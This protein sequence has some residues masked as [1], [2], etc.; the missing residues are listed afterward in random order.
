VGLTC[1]LTADR[2]VPG[3]RL[4]GVAAVR[5]VLPL[6]DAADY[7]V[8]GVAAAAVPSHRPPGRALV[9]DAASECQLARWNGAPSAVAQGTPRHDGDRPLHIAELPPDPVL[10]AEGG[11]LDA[12][13]DGS[14]HGSQWVTVG[15]G[16]DE[17]HLLR[18]DLGRNGG[19][20]VIGP[21]GSGRTRTLDALVTEL[22]AGGVPVLRVDH[23]RPSGPDELAFERWIDPRDTE[24]LAAWLD[25]LGRRGGVVVADDVGPAQDWPVLGQLASGERSRAPALIVAGSPAELAAHYQGPVAALRRARCGLLLCPGP[26][27]ADVLGIRLPRTPVPVRPGSGWLVTGGQL[28]R[29]QVAARRVRRP[30]AVG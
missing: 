20:L 14:A 7:A 16:G 22:T 2:A 17:G 9:G 10:P 11:S 18:W 30:A 15:P 1:V 8:A 13:R 28:T 12:D 24:G 21:P 19:L 3:S 27:E 5:L 4:A 29:V 23:R 6:A 26:A 25:D